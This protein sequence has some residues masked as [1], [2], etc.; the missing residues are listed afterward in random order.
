MDAEQK[1]GKNEQIF[2]TQPKQ[3]NSQGWMAQTPRAGTGD[4]AGRFRRYR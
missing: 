1:K 3:K 4:S 2:G